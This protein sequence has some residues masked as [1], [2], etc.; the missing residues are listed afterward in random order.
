MGGVV[1]VAVGKEKGRRED[2]HESLLCILSSS[3]QGVEME[4]NGRLYWIQDPRDELCVGD[5]GVMMPCGDANLWGV[6]K[7]TRRR[8]KKGT[9]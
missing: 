2:G 4:H 1:G 7:E 8:G 6:R 3:V 9:G 5:A